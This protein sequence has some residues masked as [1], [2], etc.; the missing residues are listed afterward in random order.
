MLAGFSVFTLISLEKGLAG[1]ASCGCFG[2]LIEVNPFLT[3]I[4]DLAI[5]VVLLRWRPIRSFFSIRRAIAVVVVWMLIGIP[6]A[7]AMATYTPL[8][9]TDAGT[10]VGN[11]KLVVLKP[12]SWIG[13]RCPLLPFINDVPDLSCA[14]VASVRDKLTEGKWLI[15]LYHH[16]CPKCKRAL[17]KYEELARQS[18]INSMGPR[19]LLVE[20][21]PYRS[22]FDEANL[23]ESAGA[24]SAHRYKRLV[25]RH[26]DRNV[27]CRRCRSEST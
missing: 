19:V 4:G 20:M 15:V 11:G 14:A 7:Y 24:G 17:P 1:E 10:I 12:E 23:C 27:C 9:L 5:V 18:C 3:A 22:S 13:K 21:P 6:A 26:A 8:L 25:R 16:D 2:R